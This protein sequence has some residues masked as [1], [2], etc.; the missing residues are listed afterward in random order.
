MELCQTCERFSDSAASGK[1]AAASHKGSQLET[2]LVFAHN[3]FLIQPNQD[4]DGSRKRDFQQ[5]ARLYRSSVV[6]GKEISLYG[7]SKGD[8][9]CPT[10]TQEQILADLGVNPL[11]F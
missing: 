7:Q 11:V 10:E 8:T 2:C 9:L 5:L 1:N 4:V 3:A 6:C